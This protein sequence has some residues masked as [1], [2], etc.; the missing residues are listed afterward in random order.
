MEKYE[1]EKSRR[2]VVGT[3]VVIVISLFW[4]HFSVEE[5]TE[6]TAIEISNA[7]RVEMKRQDV[8]EIQRQE[9]EYDKLKALANAKHAMYNGLIKKLEKMA[10]DETLSFDE[11]YNKYKEK[12][13][14]FKTD[15]LSDSSEWKIQS[16]DWGKG[17]PTVEQ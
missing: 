3:L 5:T 2:I 4:L 15:L 14:L 10:D 7:G 8:M 11:L 12:L 9:M 1:V 16:V 6:V 17:K 13:Q